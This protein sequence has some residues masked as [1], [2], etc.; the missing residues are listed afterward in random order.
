MGAAAAV[1]IGILT[2]LLAPRLPPRDWRPTASADEQA[3]ELGWGHPAPVGPSAT[4]GWPFVEKVALVAGV[5]F[6]FGQVLP[7]ADRNPIQVAVGAAVIIGLSTFVSQLLA[8]TGVTWRSTAIQ[9]VAMSIGNIATVLGIGLVL[10]FERVPQ[11]TVAAIFLVELL[12]LIV[13]LYDR[14]RAIGRGR[15]NRARQAD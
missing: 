15:S 11:P 3:R 6:A 12:T 13:L 9:F 5:G 2:R 14:S 1:A 4:W 7:G 8:R 10:P